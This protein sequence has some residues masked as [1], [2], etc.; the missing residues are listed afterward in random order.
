MLFD[1]SV[2]RLDGSV[3]RES[4]PPHRR[5][6][7]LDPVDPLRDNVRVFKVPDGILSVAPVLGDLPVLGTDP[8]LFE[9]IFFLRLMPNGI[10]KISDSNMSS[11]THDNKD[12]LM[13]IH[14]RHRIEILVNKTEISGESN[15]PNALN[16]QVVRDISDLL[17]QTRPSNR[18]GSAR[19]T[20]VSRLPQQI[21]KIVFRDRLVLCDLNSGI[22]KV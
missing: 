20:H 2:N 18:V 11:I 10:I 22:Q 7:S 3:N 14:H 17:I 5:F 15:D 6:L 9:E 21:N 8:Q 16:E 13:R 19:I 4:D 12:A 1:V